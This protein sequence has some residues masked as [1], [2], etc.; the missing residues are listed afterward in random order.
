M[1]NSYLFGNIPIISY[2]DPTVPTVP[3]AVGQVKPLI[4]KIF[5]TKCLSVPLSHNFFSN[6]ACKSYDPGTIV[7][8]IAQRVIRTISELVQH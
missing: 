8:K 7:A 5:L 2:L 6:R 4:I 1:N 3:N